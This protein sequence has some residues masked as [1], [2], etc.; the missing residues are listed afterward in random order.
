[1]VFQSPD[2][3]ANVYSFVP[4]PLRPLSTKK[5]GKDL[6][7]DSQVG[8]YEGRWTYLSS[9]AANQAA[10]F[11]RTVK[12]D[13]AYYISLLVIGFVLRPRSPVYYAFGIWQRDQVLTS[14]LGTGITSLHFMHCQLEGCRWLVRILLCKFI[15]VHL[16]H[17]TVKRHHLSIA[18]NYTTVSHIIAA[19]TIVLIVMKNMMDNM[20]W[21]LGSQNSAW[22]CYPCVAPVASQTAVQM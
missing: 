10:L 13:H 1:M 14:R 9:R 17:S 8:V 5:L 4:R 18:Q 19:S 12:L 3:P 21:P 20:L 15:A 22:M 7:R 2:I 16:P 6:E 11:T